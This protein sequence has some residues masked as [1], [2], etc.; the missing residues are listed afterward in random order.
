MITLEDINIFRMPQI[1]ERNLGL[2]SDGVDGQVII[3]TLD[4]TRSGIVNKN[5]RFYRPDKMKAGCSSFVKPYGKPFLVHHKD[6][7]D[8]I[9]I[10]LSAKFVDIASD[11]FKEKYSNWEDAEYE[12]ISTL[13]PQGLGKIQLTNTI[14]DEEAV[15]KALDGR[16]MGISV[17]F[18]TNKF[19]CRCGHVWYDESSDEP[20]PCDHTPGSVVDDVRYFLIPDE[21][22]YK[23]SAV[24]NHPADELARIVETQFKDSDA[25][26]GIDL[27]AF[28]KAQEALINMTD[29]EQKNIFEQVND[30]EREAFLEFCDSIPQVVTVYR[31]IDNISYSGYH[32][33]D[34]VNPAGKHGHYDEDRNVPK[35]IDGDHVHDANN[36]IGLH[37]HSGIKGLPSNEVKGRGQSGAHIHDGTNYEGRHEHQMLEKKGDKK[38]SVYVPDGSINANS[39]NDNDSDGGSASNNDAK[40]TAKQRNALPKSAFCGPKHPKTGKPTFPANDKPHVTAGLRLIGRAKW[41][42][43]VQKARTIACLKRKGRKMGMKFSDAEIQKLMDE[44]EKITLADIGLL[45]EDIGDDDFADKTFDE[46]LEIPRI[47]ELVED[48]TVELKQKL[49]AAEKDKKTLKTAFDKIKEEYEA[50]SERTEELED[51]LKDNLVD[52]L[53]ELRSNQ[54]GN[55][56][57]E[58]I[59]GIRKSL[60]ERSINSLK[61]AIAD[62]QVEQPKDEDKKDLDKIDN[63]GL[64]GEDEQAKDK[65]GHESSS[66]ELSDVQSRLALKNKDKNNE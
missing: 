45:K 47:K 65:K 24:V 52:K 37:K 14:S 21:M 20:H 10:T 19:T 3:A 49:V 62:T 6:D 56:T 61:D 38:V 8:A 22:K 17:S 11:E 59:D 48:S 64:G 31:S 50:L 32:T 13:S 7:V 30:G 57:K 27:F 42:S 12:E 66:G 4:A 58:Q 63:P 36:L 53:I 51:A 29:A 39:V 35:K 43:A 54:Y 23:H 55:K 25:V 34:L 15:K 60:L 1:A 9:G 28:N 44:A 41:I 2:F 46:L 33:H 5:H 26:P 16:Y 40:L 18:D